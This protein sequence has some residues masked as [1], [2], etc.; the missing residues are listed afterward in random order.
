MYGQRAVYRLM[1]LIIMVG[2]TL[3]VSA[4]ASAD[5]E[6]AAP[7]SL[8][9]TE[10]DTQL[11]IEVAIAAKFWDDRNVL[12]CPTTAIDIG[13]MA[14]EIGGEAELGSCRLTMNRLGGM[15]EARWKRNRRR[16]M[17]AALECHV[18]IHEMGHARGLDHRPSGIMA[19]GVWVHYTPWVCWDFAR[20]LVTR[21][22]ARA[23]MAAV[24]DIVRNLPPPTPSLSDDDT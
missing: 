5:R 11:W 3:A 14:R 2:T 4:S 18:V 20:T 19:P 23:G 16:F 13:D 22:A 24:R 10:P 6:R 21:R 12:G 15:A 17:E 1:F 7:A 9:P 8:A